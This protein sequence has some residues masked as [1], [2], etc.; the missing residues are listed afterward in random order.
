MEFKDA[1]T[2]L[3]DAGV[4][5]PELADEIGCS[6]SAL[7][8]ARMDPESEHYRSPPDGW[9]EGV[10]TLARQRGGTLCGLA[11]DLEGEEG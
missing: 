10:Q 6:I 3:M 8:Q 2:K 5:L 11:D 4:T 7:R 1:T 9:R